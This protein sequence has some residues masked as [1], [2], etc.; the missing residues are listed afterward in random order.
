MYELIIWYVHKSKDMAAEKFKTIC[1]VT[2]NNLA[3]YKFC[4]CKDKP[5]EDEMKLKFMV[6]SRQCYLLF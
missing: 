2:E 3:W 4:V 6:S 5:K 1:H